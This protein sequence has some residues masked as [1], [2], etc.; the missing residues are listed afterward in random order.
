M[1]LARRNLIWIVF[2]SFMI[3]GCETLRMPT[4]PDISS[5][6]FI[7]DAPTVG[8]QVVDSRSEERIGS[9]G[10]T[11]MY[12]K[13]KDLVPVAQNYLL[14][15]LHSM[16]INGVLLQQSGNLNTLGVDGLLKFKID[17][18]NVISIDILL[19][20]PEFEADGTVTL[21]TLDRKDLFIGH[22]RGRHDSRALTAT[23]GGKAVGLAINDALLKLS[24]NQTFRKELKSLK[25]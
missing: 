3:Q 14:Q 22:V 16:G 9:I 11:Q 21:Q 10:A 18:V 19:D 17:N 1:R 24:V 12:I 23:G 20:K 15:I 25:N 8:V 6:D 5:L 13:K 4:G 2:L 7:K